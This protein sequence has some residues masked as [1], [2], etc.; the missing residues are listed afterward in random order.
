MLQQ[1]ELDFRARGLPFPR[2]EPSP[3]DRRQPQECHLFSDPACPDAPVVLHFP[4]VNASF[5]DHS[6]PGEAAPPLLTDSLAVCS[7]QALTWALL[8][9]CGQQRERVLSLSNPVWDM[10]EPWP[11]VRA[12]IPVKSLGCPSLCQD[13]RLSWPPLP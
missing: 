13:P 3:K 12:Q 7:S 11:V 2:V 8:C 1:T 10:A 4:L 5:K 6:A 9:P